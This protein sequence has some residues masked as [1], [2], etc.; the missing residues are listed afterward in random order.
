[1]ARVWRIRDI[2]G[3]GND[4]DKEDFIRIVKQYDGMWIKEL[5]LYHRYI[6]I[7]NNSLVYFK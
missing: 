2:I 1:M 4:R 7:S 3:M 6:L 5:Y